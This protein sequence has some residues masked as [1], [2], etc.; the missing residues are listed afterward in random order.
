MRAALLRILRGKWESLF[1]QPLNIHVW[2]ACQTSAVFISLP[3][4]S[5]CLAQFCF[6]FLI[7]T[8]FCMKVF[9]DTTGEIFG[10]REGF[11]CQQNISKLLFYI[12]S[13]NY[14]PLSCQTRNDFHISTCCISH[15]HVRG[16]VFSL[17][18]QSSSL[19]ARSWVAG[20]SL[21]CWKTQLLKRI[22][23]KT[24]V[25]RRSQP[26]FMLWRRCRFSF[27]YFLPGWQRSHWQSSRYSWTDS[28]PAAAARFNSEAV[29]QF[30]L[31]INTF[32]ENKLGARNITDGK[33]NSRQWNH[34]SGNAGCHCK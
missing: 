17:S 2:H 18:V 30:Q 26:A 6:I 10:T 34:I 32:D 20:C 33:H 27:P 23:P 1:S 3:F 8:E 11:R 19:E 13:L 24:A 15:V 22:L 31:A 4:A 9:A 28:F 7:P 14:F 12:Y 21:P 25:H 29:K 5:H 16:C